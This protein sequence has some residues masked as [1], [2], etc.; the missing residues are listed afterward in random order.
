MVLFGKLLRNLPEMLL[1][2]YEYGEAAVRGGQQQ[3]LHSPFFQVLIALACDLRFDRYASCIFFFYFSI[4]IQN[5]QKSRL[6]TCTMTDHAGHGFEDIVLQLEQRV[7]PKSPKQ[8][9]FQ[10]RKHCPAASGS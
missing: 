7:F 4:S 5:L 2:Q 10:S 1:Q 3:L 9:R 6:P 8:A